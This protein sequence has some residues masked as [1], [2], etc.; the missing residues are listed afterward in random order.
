MWW[1]SPWTIAIVPAVVLA[2]LGGLMRGV[3]GWVGQRFR[4]SALRIRF[5]SEG[6][7]WTRTCRLHYGPHKAQLHAQVANHRLWL[8]EKIVTVTVAIESRD[9][10]TIPDST[11]ILQSL[12]P[13]APPSYG[14]FHKEQGGRGVRLTGRYLG[15]H[16]NSGADWT[17]GSSLELI[18]DTSAR[19]G[20]FLS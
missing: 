7:A 10:K 5:S 1:Q 2:I 12:E 6:D 15:G 11:I 17:C 19:A 4:E 18:S 14:N 13:L 9:G 8:S 3:P 16:A 20:S